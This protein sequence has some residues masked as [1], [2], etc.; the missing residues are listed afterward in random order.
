MLHIVIRIIEGGRGS[1]GRREGELKF[2]I[3]HFEV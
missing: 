1:L 2:S 3:G